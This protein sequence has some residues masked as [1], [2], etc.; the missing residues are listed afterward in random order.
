MEKHPLSGCRPAQ[1][2]G[3]WAMEQSAYDAL[4]D[5]AAWIIN[6]GQFEAIAE[7]SREMAKEADEQ[8]PYA[9]ENGVAKFSINGPM[10]RYPTSLQSALGGTATLPLQRGIRLAA[11]DSFVSSAFIEI[12]SPGGTCEGIE[13]FCAEIAKFRALK[14]VRAHIAGMGTSGGYRVGIESDVL[15]IDPMG[16]T[17]SVGVITRLRDLSEVA[18]RAGVKDH[19]IVSG[20]RKSDGAPGTVVTEEQIAA[21]Q[22]VV[23]GMSQAFLSA[24]T[25]RRPS[26][27]K[28]MADIAKAGLYAAPKALELGLVDAVTTT[29]E[30]FQRFTQQAKLGNGRS[31]P[32]RV[33]SFF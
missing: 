2:F 8:P 27:K 7:R 9:V 26:A 28:N 10:T 30:A 13:D 1:L 16:I 22:E 24:V 20:P 31:L 21:R 23:D 32:G 3:W 25:N 17:G 5:Q 33:L 29:D 15:T 4:I 11:N 18:K 19:Y 6:T 14:P 12:N